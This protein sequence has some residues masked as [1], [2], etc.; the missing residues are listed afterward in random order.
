M[1]ESHPTPRPLRWYEW[2]VILL[3]AFGAVRAQAGTVYRCADERGGATYQDRPCATATNQ[4]VVALAPMPAYAPSPRYAV[5]REEPAAAVSRL[6]HRHA[7]SPRAVTAESSYECRTADG[8]VFYRHS[9]CPHSVPAVE[10]AN[11]PPH[12]GRGAAAKSVAVTATRV[13]REDAC[14]ELRRAGAAGRR[15]RDHDED[16]STYDKNL[17][18]DPCR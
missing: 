3:L 13:S 15:G 5:D 11:G 17:G 18:R 7:A 2:L 6:P 9:A 4:S 10:H 1:F 16:V 14:Y 8:Q 12:R